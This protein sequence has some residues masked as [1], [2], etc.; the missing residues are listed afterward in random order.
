MGAD[1]EQIGKM[2]GGEMS[3]TVCS[4]PGSRRMRFASATVPIF[5]AERAC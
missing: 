2:M 1:A 3:W 4:K 5:S